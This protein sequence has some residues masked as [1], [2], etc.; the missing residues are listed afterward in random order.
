[1]ITLKK[2]S[3]AVHTFHRKS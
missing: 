3:K 2:H 1:M